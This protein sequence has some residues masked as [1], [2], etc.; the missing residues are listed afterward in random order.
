MD[1]NFITEDMLDW[2]FDGVTFY[3]TAH[4]THPSLAEL[5]KD[6]NYIRDPRTK[7]PKGCVTQTVVIDFS[8]L[9]LGEVIKRA[10]DSIVIKYQNGYA[11]KADPK[12]FLLNKD[13]SVRGDIRILVS[14]FFKGRVSA[15]PKAKVAKAVEKAQTEEELMAFQEL[16]NERLKQ[17]KA[18]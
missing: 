6:G 8:G 14:E 7:R 2:K 18:K 13:G 15:D 12:E 10:A 16:I 9:T 3:R 17:L 11:R 5:D 4:T 1:N